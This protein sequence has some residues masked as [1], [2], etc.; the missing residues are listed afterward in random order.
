ME[1][2]SIDAKCGEH[3]TYRDFI[4]CSDSWKKSRVGNIPKQLGTYQAM[5]RISKG[6]LDP[7][8][9]KFGQTYLT[10]GFSSATLVKEIK[11]NPF[12]NITP[13]GDQHASCEFNRNGNPICKRLGIAVDFY[14]GGV[15]SHEVACWVVKNTNFDRLYFYSPHSPF[16]VSV[17]EDETRSIV[18]MK[19]FL[20]G[21]HQPHVMNVDR[22]L[23]LSSF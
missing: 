16:H 5:E 22:F 7:V 12:P 4:E 6:I 20:G 14:V 9:E 10:Y 3:F 1:T 8:Y 18:H 19:G 2:S 21:R 11:K 13:A 15:S 23:N 17:G